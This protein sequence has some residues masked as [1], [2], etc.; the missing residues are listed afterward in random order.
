M[1]PVV[2]G[3]WGRIVMRAFVADAVAAVSLEVL[4]ENWLDMYVVR[5]L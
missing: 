3:Q 5:S 4:V 2:M 1:K